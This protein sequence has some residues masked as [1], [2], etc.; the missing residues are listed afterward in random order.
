[1]NAI[2]TIKTSIRFA[3]F[4]AVALTAMSTISSKEAAAASA[5]PGGGTQKCTFSCSGPV[6]HPTCVETNCT[7]SLPKATGATKV[8][9]ATSVPTNNPTRFPIT[10]GGGFSSRR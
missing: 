5:C 6:L 7:C 8:S 2:S 3:A 1:M 4:F 10:K 9:A